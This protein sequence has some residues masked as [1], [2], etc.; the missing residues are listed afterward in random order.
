MP[1]LFGDEKVP[2]GIDPEDS[3]LFSEPSRVGGGIPFSSPDEIKGDQFMIRARQIVL[4]HANQ[5]K[6]PAYPALTLGDVYIVWFAKT[7]QNWKAVLSTTRADGLIYETTH[8]G[9]LGVTY[10]DVYSKIYNQQIDDES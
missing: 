8:D 10:L 9:N 4:T 1:R 5:V 3:P 2:S 6:D 7:L